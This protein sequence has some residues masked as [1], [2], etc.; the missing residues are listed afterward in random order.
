M[1]PAMR[2]GVLVSGSGS[3]LQAL[4]DHAEARTLGA[5]ITCVVSNNP[6]AGGLDRARAHH[7]PAIAHNHRDYESREA[8]DAEMVRI[9]REYDVDLIV[10]AGFLRLVTPTLID[11]FEGRIINIH[12]SLLPAF[13][14]AH[15]QA[16]AAAF[17]PRIAG[18][19]VH[20]VD[21]Q[22]DHGPII[23]QAAVPVQP[24]DDTDALA[25]RILTMEHRILPQAIRWLA[26]ERISVQGRQVHLTPDLAHNAGFAHNVPALVQPP[27]ENPF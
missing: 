16:D 4:I 27:L 21:E 12:P 8:Y 17:R 20:Y 14:G 5:D 3:N 23:I 6:D 13:T 9:L 1:R 10:M 22:L 11:P 24:D 2:I 7:L 19:T 26:D 15:A 18:C 25:A